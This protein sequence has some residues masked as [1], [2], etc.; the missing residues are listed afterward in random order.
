M[1][2]FDRQKRMDFI[3]QTTPGFGP[4]QVCPSCHGEKLVPHIGEYET[5]YMVDGKEM[6]ACPLCLGSGTHCDRLTIMQR[7]AM[8]ILHH[9]LPEEGMLYPTITPGELAKLK[10]EVK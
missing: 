2:Y 1:T 7:E 8:A 4:E 6:R 10:G 3:M 5:L 9:G